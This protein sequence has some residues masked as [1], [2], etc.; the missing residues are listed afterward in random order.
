MTADFLE[1]PLFV[2]ADSPVIVLPDAQPQRFIVLTCRKRKARLHE[3]GTDAVSDAFRQNVQAYQLDGLRT[4]DAGIRSRAVQFGVPD[5][6]AGKFGDEE[7][8][9]RVGNFL[10]ESGFGKAF[11]QVGFQVFGGVVFFELR[12]ER[13]RAPGFLTSS[14]RRRAW[15][16]GDL[17]LLDRSIAPDGRALL[18]ARGAHDQ[19]D[20]L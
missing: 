6:L 2:K 10:T 14:D 18:Q 20:E 8:G 5:G 16:S 17:V 7:C 1:S 12:A 19:V 13:R 4:G 11:R 9:K 15:T 3:P